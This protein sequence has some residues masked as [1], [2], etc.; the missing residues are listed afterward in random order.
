MKSGIFSGLIGFF[1]I[2]LIAFFAIGFADSISEPT[3]ATALAQ[4]NNLSQVTEIS[5][6][7]INAVLLIL[8]VAMVIGA[9]LFLM[10]SLKRR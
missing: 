10:S 9:A 1:A 8:I 4:Y 5:A 3:D 7:G 6:T 2:F